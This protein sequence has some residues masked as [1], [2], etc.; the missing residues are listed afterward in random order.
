MPL[1]VPKSISLTLNEEQLK[2]L[3]K[4]HDTNGDGRLSKDELLQAFRK[5]GSRN[6]SWRVR[7]SLS[8]ADGNGDGSI[9]LEELD[10]LVKYAVKQGYGQFHM[11]E[12]K[13]VSSVAIHII[14]VW[15]DS[16]VPLINRLLG[17]SCLG[18]TPIA[19]LVNVSGDWDWDQFLCMVSTSVLHGNND[20]CPP[21]VALRADVPA[22]RWGETRVFSSRSA[23]S[24]IALNTAW[25]TALHGDDVGGRCFRMS[26]TV[27]RHEQN[28][29]RGASMLGIS[30]RKDPGG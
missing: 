17:I 10:E 23:Y 13:Q 2:A 21:M 4:E 3:F 5:L 24:A 18:P 15:L 8:H 11:L 20:V 28:R 19:S 12:K 25:S 7:R 30:P 9:G 22:W 14:D 27:L 26:C 6:P 16:D 1:F 29:R